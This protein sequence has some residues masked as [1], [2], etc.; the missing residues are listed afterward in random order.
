[1]TRAISVLVA[2]LALLT[3]GFFLGR[4]PVGDYR[5]QLETQSTEYLQ[6]LT[7]A[8]EKASRAE[9]R[10]M[11]W[12]ARAELLLAA[13]D[14]DL[15]NFGTAAERTTRARDLVTRA[16][17]VPGNTLDLN[18]AQQ[19][20]GAAGRKLGSMEPDAKMLLLRAASELGRLL[21]KA[22]QA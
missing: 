19:T 16:S 7:E 20:L 2:V 17:A 9:A 10:G 13:H 14:V 8:Q 3:V 21:D 12:E 5:Q 11:L 15:K 4:R 1:M 22:G 18:Q 6:K